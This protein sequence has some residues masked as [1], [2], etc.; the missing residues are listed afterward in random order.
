[1]V[2]TFQLTRSSNKLYLTHRKPQ[3]KDN[4]I[5]MRLRRGSCLV[6]SIQLSCAGPMCCRSEANQ[7]LSMSFSQVL[8]E[9]DS[10]SLPYRQNELLDSYVSIQ[11]L[12]TR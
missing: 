2:S 7:A 12:Q 9:G 5:D 11:C 4:A 8:D 10:R 6:F 3:R 1:M